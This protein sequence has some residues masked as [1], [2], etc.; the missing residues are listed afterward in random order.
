[1][2]SASHRSYLEVS[3]ARLDQAVQATILRALPNVAL[4]V[5][6]YYSLISIAH[7]VILPRPTSIWMSAIAALSALL[8]LGLF[9]F[10]RRRI[11]HPDWAKPIALGI[12]G[13][14]S[15]NIYVHLYLTSDPLQ[16]TNIM[17]ALILFGVLVPSARALNITL[18]LMLLIW[19]A[20]PWLPPPLWLNATASL[21]QTPLAIWVHLGFG[22]AFAVAASLLCHHLLY[23]A[24]RQTEELRIQS[25][26]LLLNILPALIA[27]RLKHGEEV[28][29]DDF[30]EV[31]VLFADIVDFTPI[32]AGLTPRQIVLLLNQIFS[33]ID[34]LVARF[35]LEKIKTIGD[36]YMVVGGL[37]SPR[38]DHLA[39]VA[40]MA[41]ALQ[42]AVHDFHLPNG[43]PVHIR[44]GIH[45]GSVVAGVIGFSKFSYDL[46][47]DTVNLASR[48]ESHGVRQQI[49]VSEAV[50]EGLKDRYRFQARGLVQIKGKGEL[51]T[52]FLM[53]KIPGVQDSG[54]AGVPVPDL[55]S[56][57]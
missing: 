5:V 42:Q 1:M 48:M 24:L 14:G 37:P 22:M 25:D 21:A 56:T 44:I 32:S 29:A 27:E 9:L 47:G 55:Q 8:G 34:E 53:E 31:S 4:F 41:L 35:G 57:G 51:P 54:F 10:L 2:R 39:A 43:E 3:P 50:Y 19:L 6:V 38:P 49:Q 16:T 13:I 52:Y 17:V 45:S 28:I 23:R 30:N 33:T 7:Q 36:A 15:L 46:W 40:D 18:A 12:A 20:L 11:L 26:A